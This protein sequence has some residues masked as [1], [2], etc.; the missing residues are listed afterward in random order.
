VSNKRVLQLKGFPTLEE[1]EN[2]D[3]AI[4]PLVSLLALRRNFV[5][6]KDYEADR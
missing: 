3:K 2:A 5:G 1:V 4:S 6:P